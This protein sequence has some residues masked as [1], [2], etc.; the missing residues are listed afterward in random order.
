MADSHLGFTLRNIPSSSMLCIITGT[1]SKITS[2]HSLTR[3]NIFSV[4]VD[5]LWIFGFIN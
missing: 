2:A 4:R 1:A 5:P 3:M